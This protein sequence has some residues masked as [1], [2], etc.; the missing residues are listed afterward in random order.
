[1]SEQPDYVQA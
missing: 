1:V